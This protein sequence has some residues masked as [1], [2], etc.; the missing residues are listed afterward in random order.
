MRAAD[1]KLLNLQCIREYNM[2]REEN[3]IICDKIIHVSAPGFTCTIRHKKLIHVH[4]QYEL[5]RGR[6]E[7]RGEIQ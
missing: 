6:L 2:N 3:V 7:D 1:A 4:N 5:H